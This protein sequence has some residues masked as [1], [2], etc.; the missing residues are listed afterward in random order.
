MERHPGSAQKGD[1]GST[2]PLVNDSEQRLA[3]QF[4]ATQMMASV[5]QRMIDTF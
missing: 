5:Y 3:I 1:A 4:L 2:A